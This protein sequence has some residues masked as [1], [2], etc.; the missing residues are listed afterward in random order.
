MFCKQS[1]ITWHSRTFKPRSQ[2]LQGFQRNLFITHVP[3]HVLQSFVNPYKVLQISEDADPK[4]IKKAYRKL[5][6][7][8]HPDISEEPS[9]EQDFLRIQEAYESLTNKRDA[10]QADP[11]NNGWDFHDW[12]WDFTMSRR[13]DSQWKK[14]G[15]SGPSPFASTPT[16]RKQWQAQLG[17]LKQKAAFRRSQ[18]QVHPAEDQQA[19]DQDTHR[20]WYPQ[21]ADG[22]HGSQQAAHQQDLC[23]EDSCQP[24]HQAF[25][26]DAELDN[27][28]QD[29]DGN[30]ENASCQEGS[31][32]RPGAATSTSHPIN[33]VLT[34]QL[35]HTQSSQPADTLLEG[36]QMLLSQVQ[37]C[38][39][40]V[41]HNLSTRTS[42]WPNQVD[43][44][45]CYA[46][47]QPGSAR[48]A[49]QSSHSAGVPQDLPT[50][51]S[52]SASAAPTFSDAPAENV[53]DVK[54]SAASLHSASVA[55]KASVANQV[56]DTMD[57][58]LHDLPEDGVADAAENCTGS[59]AAFQ[60]Q[61][62]RVQ[63]QLSG[64]RRRAV[65]KQDA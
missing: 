42:H 60:T 54:G 4:A 41:T 51:Q 11:K 14:Q 18:Q 2:H 65:R 9:A 31:N 3:G 28:M 22:L 23:H 19:Q 1:P 63:S 17:R 45:L 12:Y 56:E 49:N 64:L 33:G 44:L 36:T 25:I 62:S 50:V 58:S 10:A 16:H 13:W 59:R 40:Q 57:A 30:W 34:D 32:H 24:Q 37:S 7:R 20:Q 26:A 46:L 48:A 61:H 35:R 43:E 39:T 5:A 52:S 8:H 55:V 27:I 38:H 21:Q 29:H 53:S 15:K 6:L 47:E